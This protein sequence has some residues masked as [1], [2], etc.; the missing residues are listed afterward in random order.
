MALKLSKFL[1]TIHHII[2]KRFI[3]K[4]L[5]PCLTSTDRNLFLCLTWIRVTVL[6]I[7]STL[8]S[9]LEHNGR[10]FVHWKFCQFKYCLILLVDQ[11]VLRTIWP[12]VACM[13]R[14]YVASTPLIILYT[15][16]IT[17]NEHIIEN[18]WQNYIFDGRRAALGPKTPSK[19]NNWCK[20]WKFVTRM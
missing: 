14:L 9:K 16:I 4:T 20:C 1:Q 11:E 19:F 3:R 6:K 5:A 17:P 2:K 7:T 18:I 13:C 12:L 8:F 15:T 10:S